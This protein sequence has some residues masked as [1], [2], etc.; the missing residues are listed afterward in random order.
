MQCKLYV[1][2]AR[3]AK[4]ID[5]VQRRASEHLIL[6][7]AQCLGR[8]HNNTVSCV[9]AYRI[10]IFHITYGNAVSCA[11]AHY[12][13]LDL[14]PACNTTL[15]KHLTNTGQTQS[16]RQNFFQL[17]LIVGNS[18]A[19][20]SQGIRRAQYHRIADLRRKSHA[21]FNIF[22]H[23]GR[24]AGLSDLFHRLFKLQTVLRLTDGLCSRSKQGYPMLCKETGLVQLHSQIQTCLSSHVREQGIRFFFDND[25]FKHLGCQRLDINLV[26]NITVCHDGRR[27]GIDQDYLHPLFF[28][29]T[30]RLCSGVVKLCRLTD[31]DR[32]R[33][34][35]KH[36]FY[37][38][39]LRH[40]SPPSSW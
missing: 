33:A 12:F 34:D 21:V 30:A 31:H 4:L 39:I 26:R 24:S 25:L 6:L 9:D 27:I 18:A 29:G 20:S 5:D 40:F 10:D 35:H 3:D 22:Y 8:S 16:V 7:V 1:T 32:P 19:R 23:Q 37:I 14:F 15:D 11:V 36:S 2:T 28:Q 13:V 17:Y 38:W